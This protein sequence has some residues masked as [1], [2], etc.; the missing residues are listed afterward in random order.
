MIGRDDDETSQVKINKISI[1]RWE[2]NERVKNS[3]VSNSAPV[4]QL[5]HT[6]ETHRLIPHN[7]YARR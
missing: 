1:A 2:D 4:T 3:Y 6:I 5:N 7:K